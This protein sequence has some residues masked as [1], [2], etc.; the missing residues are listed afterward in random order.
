MKIINKMNYYNRLL[1]VANVAAK[2]PGIKKLLKPI[3]YPLKKYIW[4]KHNKNFKDNALNLIA[5]FT[6]TLDKNKIP[7]TIAFGTLLGGI[8]EKGFIKHDLDIDIAMWHD[9]RPD[10][11]QDI[12]NQ[13]GFKLSHTYSIEEGRL[14]LEETYIKNG[15]GIDIFY[16]YSA[17]NKHP[18]CCD[19]LPINN[20]PTPSSSMKK[21]GKVLA[22]RIEMPM[23]RE[24]M[25][26]DFENLKLP[27]PVNAHELLAFRYGHDYMIPNPN[28][29]ITSFNDYIVC[30]DE[31][32][33]IYVGD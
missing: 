10:N 21:Y 5:E 20:L 30:W 25:I 33:A 18:Y 27:A 1:E 28:W 23:T 4:R 13:I 26:I 7:Y 6:S 15:V 14:G 22:R 2:I 9:E 32:N 11:L 17:I 8:R 16:F 31:V 24:R 3:Y 29:G 12:L 19:F